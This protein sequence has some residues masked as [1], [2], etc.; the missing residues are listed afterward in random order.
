MT[1][2]THKDITTAEDIK[3]L[4]D[5]FYTKIKQDDIIGFIFTDVATVDWEHHLPKMYSFWQSILLSIEG[6]KG[7]PMQKHL[8]LNNKIQLNST[9]FDRWTLLFE[10]TIDENFSGTCAEEA[11]LRAKSI[12]M[13]WQIKLN[14]IN[15]G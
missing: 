2:I 3:I 11:K 13:V 14:H 1:I 15:Q 7:N 6:Y 9:H 10:Q 8:Q 12:A 5:N 4:V